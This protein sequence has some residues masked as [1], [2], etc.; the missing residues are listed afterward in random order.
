LFVPFANSLT[1]NPRLA[2]QKVSR[3]LALFQSYLKAECI[4]SLPI[5]SNSATSCCF[6]SFSVQ[7]SPTAVIAAT[8]PE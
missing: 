3:S 6:T 8:T 4:V 5:R 1:L 2:L 7:Q